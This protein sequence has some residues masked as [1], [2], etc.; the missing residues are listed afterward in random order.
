VKESVELTLAE[1][2]SLAWQAESRRRA[3]RLSEPSFQQAE[4]AHSLDGHSA[5]IIRP[6]SM[7]MR[8]AG[9]R[10]SERRRTKQKLRRRDFKVAETANSEVRDNEIS[11]L[12]RL[13]SK[14]NGKMKREKTRENRAAAPAQP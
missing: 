8:A 6:L 7:L 3:R 4:T 14:Q 10:R 9:P 12:G 5:T 11:G 2:G 1:P 13:K